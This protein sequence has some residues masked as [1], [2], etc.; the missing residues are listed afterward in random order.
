[1]LIHRYKHW[2]TSQQCLDIDAQ[3]NQTLVSEGGVSAL[4]V[5]VI[6]V[7]SLDASFIQNIKV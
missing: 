5:C 4:C 3:I 6:V 1:M 2:S 7:K